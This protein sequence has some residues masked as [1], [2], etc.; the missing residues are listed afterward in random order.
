MLFILSLIVYILGVA[1][2]LNAKWTLSL[3][4]R[5]PGINLES[6]NKVASRIGIVLLVVGIVLS[7]IE[8]LLI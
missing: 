6:I 7:V 5:V 4:S 2:I 8:L 3:I 1:L